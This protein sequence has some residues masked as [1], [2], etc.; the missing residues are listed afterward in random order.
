M[1]STLIDRP[2]RREALDLQALWVLVRVSSEHLVLP[3]ASVLEMV[4][5]PAA[6]AVPFTPDAVRGVAPLRGQ[7]GPVVDMRTRLG[8]ESLHA[9]QQALVALLHARER[10][11]HAWVDDLEECVRDGRTFARTVDPHECAFGK[12]Y[13]TYQAPTLE[14]AWYLRQFAEPHA[15]IHAEGAVVA[16]LVRQG[17][18][19]EA[20]ARVALAR[21][22]V[23][24]RLVQLF[25]GARQ[26]VTAS[27]REIAI[28]VNVRGRSV[29]LVV[30]EVEGID[31]LRPETLEAL[32][33]G[34]GS[35]DP[36]I[37]GTARTRR[38]DKTVV[39]VDL[40]ALTESYAAAG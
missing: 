35:S 23:L 38:D 12:W 5:A 1:D 18:Q 24:Q 31:H 8:V 29:G 4:R 6:H 25:Q 9:E 14:L 3:S 15:R 17:R 20:A 28:I 34:F 39:V 22:G 27:A 36:A 11:H 13:D 7:V 2:A 32:P 30:D 21:T 10:D 16:D 40:D 26:L 19:A 33:S 37:V